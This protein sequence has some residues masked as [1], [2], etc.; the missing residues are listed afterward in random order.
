MWAYRL[1]KDSVSAN[2]G[3]TRRANVIREIVRVE[4]EKALA[5]WVESTGEAHPQDMVKLFD[6]HVEIAKNMAASLGWDRTH[7]G[8]VQCWQ[9][10]SLT[11]IT[12]GFMITQATSG[13]RYVVSPVPLDY[14]KDYLQW[15]DHISVAEVQATQ[16]ALSGG[17]DPIK[18]AV[19][20]G[21]W[22][23]SRKGNI[24]THINGSMVTVFRDRKGGY[25]AVIVGA[26]DP[27]TGEEVKVFS[28]SF[29]SEQACAN[30]S[31]MNFYDLTS[32]W[33]HDTTAPQDDNHPF[34]GT[35]WSGGDDDEA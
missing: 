12:L 31:Y 10:P 13:R 20:V 25:T 24:Y 28:P 8:G 35:D 33:T 26:V 16:A 11:S 27:T 19:I 6:R 23:R 5:R 14:L 32:A 22:Q 1:E 9:L 34:A 7:V 4:Y 21:E 18:P 29:A 15:D 2:F 17:P 3:L 30:F